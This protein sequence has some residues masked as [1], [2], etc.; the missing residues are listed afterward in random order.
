MADSRIIAA[1]DVHTPED[2]KQLV[3]KLG[4]SVSFYKVGMELFYSARRSRT[5]R[6]RT[7]RA[8]GGYRAYEY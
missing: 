8:S 5:A 1:L 7:A 4:D 6:H 3:E 2:M